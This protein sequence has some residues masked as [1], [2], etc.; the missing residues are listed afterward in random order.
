M[1]GGVNGEL[2]AGL[3]YEFKDPFIIYSD[4]KTVKNLCKPFCK[5][6]RKY[7]LVVS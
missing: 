5:H 2:T 1:K 3:Q 4:M 7:I 6:R